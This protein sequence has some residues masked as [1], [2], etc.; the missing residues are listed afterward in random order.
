MSNHS[1]PA[2]GTDP[3]F[4]HKSILSNTH[5]QSIICSKTLIC[6]QLLRSRSGLLANERKE[7]M[8]RLIIYKQMEQ[9]KLFIRAETEAE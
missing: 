2:Q 5:E 9:N 7:K 1:L 3:I 4:S 6:K 8:H